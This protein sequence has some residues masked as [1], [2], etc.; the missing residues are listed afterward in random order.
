VLAF[1][2]TPARRLA[3]SLFWSGQLF[4]AFRILTDCH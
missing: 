3:V 4:P 1:L 2:V